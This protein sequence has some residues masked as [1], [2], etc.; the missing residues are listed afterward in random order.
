MA[1]VTLCDWT[2]G[3]GPDDVWV[4]EAEIVSSRPDLNILG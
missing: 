1:D 3:G 2:K 4:R